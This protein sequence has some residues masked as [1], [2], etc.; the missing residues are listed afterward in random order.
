MEVR[1]P[2]Y[3]TVQ[4]DESEQH[5]IG[6][7]WVQRL[8]DIRQ[9][10]FSF[11][12]FPGATHSRFAHS[13]GV[14]DLAGRAFDQAYAQWGFTD[15]SQRARFRSLV[16]LAALCHDIGHA[17]F[18][19]CT[20]F[21]MPPLG[22]LGIT[23]Y[24]SQEGARRASHEDYTIAILERTSLGEVVARHFPFTARHV[25][26][27]VCKDVEVEDDFFLDGGLD[28]RWLLSQIVSS[29]LDVDRLDYLV[30]DALHT[31]TAYGR[32]DVDW[33]IGNL[34]THVADGHV[35]LA[36]EGRAVYAF[37]HFLLARHH[38]FLQ[39]YFHHTSVAYEEHLRRYAMDPESGW[40]LSADL[41]VYRLTDDA[42]LL[43]HLK[44]V[45]HP[46]AERVANRK[47][48]VRVLERHGSEDASDVSQE[49]EFLD[50]QGIDVIQATSTGRLS[51]YQGQQSARQQGDQIYVFERLDGFPVEAVKT[52]NEASEVFSR[53]ADDR[54]IGRIYVDRED[55]VRA[56]RLLGL[57]C[58]EA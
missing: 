24:E 12:P 58:D 41:N 10:G 32:V 26:A 9:I 19:H 33:L 39:V 54:C 11:L 15:L 34:S 49:V 55:V 56:R 6:H 29:E 37:D 44:E 36:L 16:R 7:E 18:S 47:P 57:P 21:S 46:M 2:V 52:L 40:S 22:E 4:Y 35:C 53:Y 23:W 31:G 45:R 28:H 17:P 1:D 42:A 43:Q 8:R 3:G 25:A 5:V 30:R 27:L 50:G 51:R 38:M 20:E 13:L 14:M 48:Y